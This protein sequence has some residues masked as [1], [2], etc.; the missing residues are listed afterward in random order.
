MYKYLLFAFREYEASGGMDDL[1]FKFNTFDEII[2]KYEFKDLYY[3]QLVDTRDF[4]VKEFTTNIM[5][6][7]GVD[8]Y[9]SIKQS[10]KEEFI[11]WIA[12]NI[13]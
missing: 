5:Y 13:D 6:H 12:S 4:S 7:V 8:D 1:V 3:N 10:R 2:N 11:N 9:E